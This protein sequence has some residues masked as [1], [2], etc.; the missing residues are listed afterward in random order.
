MP[1]PLLKMSNA[2][3]HDLAASL[4]HEHLAVVETRSRRRWK[5]SCECGWNEGPTDPTNATAAEAVRRSVWHLESV[6]RAH[7][8]KESNGV[9]VPKVGKTRL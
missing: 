2:E 5:A 9:S 8:A 7:L 4:G 3:K 1:R 6:I